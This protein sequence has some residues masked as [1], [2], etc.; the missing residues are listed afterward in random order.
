[1][2]VKVMILFP[3]SLCTIKNHIVFESVLQEDD[4]VLRGLLFTHL[5]YMSYPTQS[6]SLKQTRFHTSEQPRQLLM[7]TLYFSIVVQF[8]TS[9]HNT[10]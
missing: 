8:K 4:R 10:V 7:N 1:M 5:Y 9:L 3:S 6:S 2:W